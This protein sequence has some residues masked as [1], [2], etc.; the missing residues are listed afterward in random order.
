MSS[1]EV[2]DFDDT[3]SE[4]SVSTTNMMQISGFQVAKV[5]NYEATSWCMVLKTAIKTK[6]L[7]T[8]QVCLQ[9][10]REMGWIIPID[11]FLSAFSE[12]DV[13]V[14]EI[15]FKQ[16]VPWVQKAVLYPMSEDMRNFVT[17]VDSYFKMIVSQNLQNGPQNLGQAIQKALQQKE[18]NLYKYAVREANFQLLEWLYIYMEEPLTTGLYEVICLDDHW[19]RL[20]NWLIARHAPILGTSAGPAAYYA[21]IETLNEMEQYGLKMTVYIMPFVIA[22]GDEEKFLHFRERFEYDMET[23]SMIMAKNRKWKMIKS[24]YYRGLVYL[25]DEMVEIA[26][27]QRGDENAIWVVEEWEDT[28]SHEGELLGTL[29]AEISI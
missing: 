4:D 22:S 8:I 18:G 12:G 25:T 1:E 27:E 2:E 20:Y 17:T 16:G 7:E 28:K 21:N 23:A 6:S 11:V 19:K 10:A 29:F 3:I 15:L 14:V 13:E 24:L 9:T 5:F 26:R